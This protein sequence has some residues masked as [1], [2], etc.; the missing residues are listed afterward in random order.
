MQVPENG[1]SDP[2]LAKSLEAEI[3]GCL[4]ARKQRLY[5]EIRSYPTP[6]TA[7]DQQFNYLL[8]QQADVSEELARL[9]N[10]IAE[11]PSGG[12]PVA[13]LASLI[14]SLSSIDDDTKERLLARLRLLEPPASSLQ[15]PA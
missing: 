2:A 13:L 6:I 1:M 11:G 5:D 9:K 12:E 10:L 14:C 3:A 4:E 15:S 8:A 7:C